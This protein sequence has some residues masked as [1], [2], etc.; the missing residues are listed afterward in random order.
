MFHHKKKHIFITK[1]LL[2]CSG[3]N[4]WPLELLLLFYTENHLSKLLFLQI[5]GTLRQPFWGFEQRHQRM[6]E[7]NT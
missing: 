3:D 5:F 2:M 1:L 4:M 7:K 6:K